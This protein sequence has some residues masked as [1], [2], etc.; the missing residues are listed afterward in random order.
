MKEGNETGVS[1]R[2]ALPLYRAASETVEWG[3]PV[4]FCGKVDGLSLDYLA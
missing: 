1:Q 3:L 2:L 4:V